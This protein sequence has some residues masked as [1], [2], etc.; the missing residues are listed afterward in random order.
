M[1]EEPSGHPSIRLRYV[2]EPLGELEQPRI[3]IATGRLPQGVERA[4]ER[5]GTDRRDHHGDELPPIEEV[6]GLI[7]F[8]HATTPLPWHVP[9]WPIFPWSN[10]DTAALGYGTEM[11]RGA[12][13]ASLAMRQAGCWTRPVLLVWGGAPRRNRTGDPILTIDA[14]AVHDVSRHLTSPHIR[15]GERRCRGLEY[16]AT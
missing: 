6:V 8:G 11:A 9:G 16:G 13:S 4:L 10:G 14:P 7:S 3:R 1:G 15:A 5:R 12:E 2:T